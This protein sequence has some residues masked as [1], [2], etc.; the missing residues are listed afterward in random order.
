MIIWQA[1]MFGLASLHQLRG[2]VGRA[3]EQAYAVMTYPKGVCSSVRRWAPYVASR[4]WVA[5]AA[6]AA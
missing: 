6:E 2:R 4:K 1:H 3:G 5:A